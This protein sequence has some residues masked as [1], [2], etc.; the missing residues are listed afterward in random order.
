ML[1]CFRFEIEKEFIILQK[2]IAFNYGVEQKRQSKC[3]ID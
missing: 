3:L 2:R 1:L